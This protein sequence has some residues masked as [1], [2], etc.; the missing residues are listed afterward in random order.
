MRRQHLIGAIIAI[1]LAGCQSVRSDDLAA[2]EGSPVAAL[3]THPIFLTMSVVRSV[4]PDGTEIRNYVNGRNVS[5]CS[6]GGTV[7]G[8]PVDFA[9]YSGF[10]SCM[11]SYAACNNIFYI[12]KGIVAAY[13][14]I[15]TGGGKCFT[16]ERAR[17]GFRGPA[18]I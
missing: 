13:T 15:G 7:F 8:G 2:W 9:T 4:T 11:S 10:S 18:N 5:E 1:A 16:D 6:R 12:K 17:P 14:P 3:D